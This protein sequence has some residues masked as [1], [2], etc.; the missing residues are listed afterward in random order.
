MNEAIQSA[1]RFAGS[2]CLAAFYWLT[3]SA[4]IS[5]F[6]TSMDASAAT[7]NLTQAGFRVLYMA[8]IFVAMDKGFFAKH[9]VSLTFKEIDSG[10]L[11]PAT[12]LSGA[13]QISD[14]DPGGIAELKAHG[15][16]T[17]M[18]YN[19]V[20]RVTLDLI[21]RN[22]AI[23]KYG[24]KLDAPILDRAKAMKFLTLG[25]TRPGA[26]TDVYPRY[27]IAKAG[28]DPTRDINLVQIGAIPALEAAFR[29]GR[30][31][32]FM[33]SPPLP[34]KLEQAGIGKIVIRNT[35]GDMLELMDT[36]YDTLFTS[37]EFA[38]NNGAAL[39]A[40]CAAIEE[41]VEWLND[42]QDEAV[43]FL[44]S[45]WFS[46]TDKPT[47]KLSLRVLLP[48]LSRTGE[49][50]PDSVAKYLNVSET[51]GQKIDADLSEDVLWT[52]KFVK[53]K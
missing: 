50:K 46:D 3:L 9:D 26:P 2:G 34:Q 49:F 41:G 53:A 31:D 4:V 22:D 10:A 29:A 16:S 37:A 32:G 48:S 47:L 35:A 43:D 18:F 24:L 27:F 42:N 36:S 39:S 45:K 51:L 20:N 40:Y 25:I 5:A 52:N 14:L 7:Y 12:V 21:V 1:R 44:A 30:I 23:E 6:F 19:L 38:A 8:P 33:L 15:K 11:G 13:A 17:I 28:L